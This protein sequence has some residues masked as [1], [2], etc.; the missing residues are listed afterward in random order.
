[1]R[2]SFQPSGVPRLPPITWRPYR[3][4][5]GACSTSTDVQSTSRHSATTIGNAV[6]T[7]WP[8]SGFLLTMVT[9]LSVSMRIYRLGTQACPASIAP[10]ARSE[11]PTPT[12]RAPEA[13]SAL[14]AYNPFVHPQFSRHGNGHLISYN[15]NHVHDPDTLYDDAGL[16]RPRFIW[17]DLDRLAV[18]PPGQER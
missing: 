3:S 12:S 11:R 4:S 16:Y 13:S 1:M 6:L 18:R 2:R 10:A 17:V 9:R 14:A 15:I 8:A 5:S 7:P